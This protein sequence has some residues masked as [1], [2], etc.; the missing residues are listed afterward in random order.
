MEDKALLSLI[1]SELEEL[2]A[3]ETLVLDVKELTTITDTMIITSGRSTRHVKAVAKKLIEKLKA[4]GARPL[5][6]NGVDQGEWALIDCGEVL[7]HIMLPQVRAFYHLEN[8][9]QH[10]E[11]KDNPASNEN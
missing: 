4:E 6:S 10:Q 3:F 9:W 5:S 8:L 11:P 1:E 2:Q 7:I